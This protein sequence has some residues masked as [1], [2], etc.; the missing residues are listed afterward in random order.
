MESLVSRHD[1]CSGY[2]RTS[3]RAGH[4]I[5]KGHTGGTKVD[6]RSNMRLRAFLHAGLSLLIASVQLTAAAGAPGV[7]P[8]DTGNQY[9]CCCI[10]ECH[11]TAD[12]CNH[13]P[14][15]REDESSPAVRIGAGGPV[16]EAPR[17]CGTT[18]GTL[19]RPP[20]EHKNLATDLRRDSR[21]E[22]DSESSLPE[23]PAILVL[24]DATPG[25]A[26]PRG[27]PASRARA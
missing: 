7:R 25:P 20:Q 5:A 19:Q 2:Q 4:E 17:S 14:A 9:Y 1:Y 26:S 8:A 16:L 27:P 18:Q 6:E 23:S 21:L 11:C 12:C 15:N 10:G 22:I 3:I 24:D 13:P